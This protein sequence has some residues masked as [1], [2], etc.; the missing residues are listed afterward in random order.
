MRLEDLN[1]LDAEDAARE[2]LRCCGSTRWARQMTDARP[3]AD[4][5]AMTAAGD[6]IWASLAPA[7]W[8]EAFAAHPRIGETSEAGGSGGSGRSDGPG[9]SDRSGGSGRSG[10]AAVSDWSQQEQAGVADA[11]NATLRRLAE[12]N[13]QYE[14]RF[15]Y[16]FIVRATGRTAAEMLDRLERRLQNEPGVELGVA[17]EE[18]R[19]IIRLRLA[20]L[21]GTEQVTT[22]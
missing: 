5:A 20:K 12:A 21:I 2:M 15:G 10:A 13:H 22:T 9:G 1:A 18:Q 6:A 11:A 8:L 19:K 14:T 7:D 16:I 3:F 17:A 4:A